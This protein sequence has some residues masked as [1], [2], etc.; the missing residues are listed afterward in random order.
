M[1]TA[2]SVSNS[3]G[4]I[5]SNCDKKSWWKSFL[6]ANWIEETFFN[7][8]KTVQ[9][10]EGKPGGGNASNTFYESKSPT[11]KSKL[12][13]IFDE[14][15]VRHLCLHMQERK[16]ERLKD[17]C[18]P[19]TCIKHCS[20]FGTWDCGIACIQ[21]A[22]RWVREDYFQSV[23]S[24][25]SE[26]ELQEREWMLS[27]IGTESIWTI[28]LVLLLEEL[29]QKQKKDEK[30]PYQSTFSYLFCSKLLGVNMRYETI[31]YYEKGFATDHERITKGLEKIEK[32]QLPC[33]CT[34]E[35]RFDK[36]LETV[37]KNENCVALVLVDNSILK[38]NYRNKKNQYTGHYVIL[39][40]IT[41]DPECVEESDNFLDSDTP[42]FDYCLVLRDP[43]QQGDV[44]MTPER[45]EKAW[46]AEG[47]DNDVIFFSKQAF[48]S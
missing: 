43:A 45:F 20:Q 28:D 1:Q 37:S 19:Y 36:L 11:D 40:G 18:V 22:L 46:K 8:V 31:G 47:T 16:K 21:M 35:L 27:L 24:N 3:V 9:S 42:T 32:M 41:H 25:I 48:K 29:L 38:M 6:D 39:C 44:Y 13:K 26:V 2:E 4:K 10:N 14:A 5:D 17:E 34:P 12:E 7:R 15:V 33:L 23:D 30:N